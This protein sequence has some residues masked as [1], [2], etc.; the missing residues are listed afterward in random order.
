MGW[1]SGSAILEEIWREVREFIPEPKRANIFEK[2]A[3]VQYR[4]N[5]EIKEWSPLQWH[6]F[7]Q[8]TAHRG[9]ASEEHCWRCFIRVIPARFV[10]SMAAHIVGTQRRHTQ[11]YLDASKFTW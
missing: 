9:Q 10:H 7:T 2:L 3:R 6:G 4:E 11:V 1:A 8:A 5:G